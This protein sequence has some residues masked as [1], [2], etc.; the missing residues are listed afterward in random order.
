MARLTA[1]I[2]VT[3]SPVSV[4]DQEIF[5][6][7]LIVTVANPRMVA[8]CSILIFQDSIYD[9]AC[10]WLAAFYICQWRSLPAT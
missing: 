7:V 10:V 4:L 9:S 6:W 2:I 5:E 8:S 3:W 1:K